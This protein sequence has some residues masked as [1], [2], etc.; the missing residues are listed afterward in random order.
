MAGSAECSPASTDRAAAAVTIHVNAR[1]K[2]T[3]LFANETPPGQ[4]PDL[5]DMA[6]LVR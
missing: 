1:L 6:T 3:S 2:D 4:A 5:L